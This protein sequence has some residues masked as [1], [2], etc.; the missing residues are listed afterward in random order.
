MKTLSAQIGFL[1]GAISYYS[2]S[3]DLAVLE[4]W[5][6]LNV[7]YFYRLIQTKYFKL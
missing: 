5:V 4:I 1:I 7:G 2:H 3:T 6:T